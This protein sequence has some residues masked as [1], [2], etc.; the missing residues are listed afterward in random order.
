MTAPLHPVG[1]ADFWLA[2]QLN[3]L[4]VVLLDFQFL[5]CFY[6]FEVDWLPNPSK[7]Q[8]VHDKDMNVYIV[9]ISY[10]TEFIR[11]YLCIQHNRLVNLCCLFNYFK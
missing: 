8:T 1:F 4:T 2:D 7:W 10:P 11:I 3:S 9:Q 5:I 6:A